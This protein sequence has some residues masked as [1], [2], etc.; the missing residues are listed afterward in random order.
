MRY[1]LFSSCSKILDFLLG[2]F[3][4][5]CRP[6][7]KSFGPLANCTTG[8]RARLRDGI[9]AALAGTALRLP[10]RRPA[11]VRRPKAADG[12]RVRASR[13][14]DVRDET[15]ERPSPRSWRLKRASRF[16]GEPWGKG[17]VAC[18][19]RTV[20]DRT[21]VPQ[22]RG[23][24]AVGTCARQPRFVVP[25]LP[26]RPFPAP[27]REG[28]RRPEDAYAP[29]G[30]P[31]GSRP[32]CPAP[33]RDRPRG[34]APGSHGDRLAPVVVGMDG[35]SARNRDDVAT[36]PHRGR[37]WRPHDPAPAGN[38]TI[39]PRSGTP[40]AAAHRSGSTVGTAIVPFVH[41]LRADAPSPARPPSPS[42][43]LQPAGAGGRNGT[44]VPAEL[45]QFKPRTKWGGPKRPL[46]PAP[47][48]RTEGD[49][50]APVPD[51]HFWPGLAPPILFPLVGAVSV[52][53]PAA[54]RH[55]DVAVALR[56]MPEAMRCRERNG[57]CEKRGQG[58]GP[59][60]RCPRRIV[61]R[62]D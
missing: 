49:E 8:R 34:D 26:P 52:V 11:C 30:A 27:R 5:A 33:W 14:V 18:A 35:R 16:F 60:S 44:K 29:T 31:T 28:P 3:A 13:R 10:S 12:P 48:R 40:S 59:C 45:I 2:D 7:L 62:N 21:V 15:R 53:A 42:G 1:V 4:A 54:P 56:F 24:G 37:A 41:D 55:G 20:L 57:L 50:K 9:R 19:G 58:R 36:F 39:F 61:R 32:G 47:A 22:A 23:K 17:A 43:N 46:L 38:V 25:P 51:C 6:A